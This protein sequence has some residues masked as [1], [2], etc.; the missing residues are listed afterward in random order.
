MGQYFLVLNL[1]K[2]QYLHPHCFGDGLKLL[3]FGSSAEGTLTG[4]TLLLRKSTEGG[5]GDWDG[6]HEIVGTWAGDRS[7]IVGDYDE[8][9]LYEQAHEEWH[10]ISHHVLDAMKQDP[11]LA[12]ALAEMEKSGFSYHAGGV[13]RHT[14]SELH[15]LDTRPPYGRQPTDSTPIP[16]EVLFTKGGGGPH[17]A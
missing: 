6:S 13:E 14:R 9:G 10:N 12:Q 17:G 16:R 7:A 8:S 3:E 11:Y 5:G 15:E 2:R 1:D 4:L